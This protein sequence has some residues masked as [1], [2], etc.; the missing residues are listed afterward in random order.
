MTTDATTTTVAP[1]M[2]QMRRAILAIVKRRGSAAIGELAE[3][4][5][6]SYEASRQQV[7]QLHR[8][9]WLTKRIERG[10][11]R[12]RVGRPEARY[13]LTEAGDHLFP[14]Q[15]DGL[16]VALIDSLSAR[17]GTE[18]LLTVLTELAD[19]RVREWAPRLEGLDLQERLEALQGIYLDEDPFVSVERAEDGGLRLVERNCPF[20]NVAL[21]RPALCS[22]T[23]SVL[24]RLLGCRVV[25]E[26]R[27]QA[28]DSCCAFRVQEDRPV[29]PEA[30]RFELETPEE[31]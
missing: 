2:S 1:E 26:K 9:G 15:Y 20:L 6:V 29:D 4:L 28:G 17:F 21:E 18:G 16:A 19:S 31:G 24:T 10:P 13:H 23:V 3:E 25:R 22:L 27:F 30:F 12:S 8:E 11:G 5:Q 14:K 7:G